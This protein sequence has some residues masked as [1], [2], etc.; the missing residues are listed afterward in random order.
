[1]AMMERGE[2][3]LKRHLFYKFL[4]LG[5]VLTLLTGCPKDE[6]SGKQIATTPNANCLTYGAGFNGNCNYNY[7]QVNGFTN[8]PYGPNGYYRGHNNNFRNGFCDCPPGH[9]PVYNGTLGLGCINAS[10]VNGSGSYYGSNQYPYNSY[11]NGGFG[12]FGGFNSEYNTGLGFG[13]YVGGSLGTSPYNSIPYSTYTWN[14]QT[15]SFTSQVQPYNPLPENAGSNGCYSNVLGSCRTDIT[16]S[17]GATGYCRPI[18]GGTTL[19]IC[20]NNYYQ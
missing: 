20:I 4:V 18:A 17:C 3:M 7:N 11:T 8:Y 19:G 13:G 16:G 15:W 9:R 2:K 12:G 14:T 1:M 10:Y 6:P 5:S